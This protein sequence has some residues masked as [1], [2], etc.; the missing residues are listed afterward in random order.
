MSEPLPQWVRD[1]RERR[2]EKRWRATKEKIKDW[3]IIFFIVLI[4]VLALLAILRGIYYTNQGIPIAHAEQIER[5]VITAV[6]TAYNAV[7]EQTDSTPNI[8]ASGKKAKIGMI[9]CP[10]RYAFGVTVEISGDKYQCED[11]MAERYRNGDFF[12]ILVSTKKEAFAWG[13]Q[14]MEVEIL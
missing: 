13:R 8:T 9:A 14:V 11:R 4:P 12:D 2:R 7:E 3:L 6:V 5:N 1:D 10:V